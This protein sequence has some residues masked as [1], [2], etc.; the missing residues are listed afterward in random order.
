M[1]VLKRTGVYINNQQ[2]TINNKGREQ[3]ALKGKGKGKRKKFLGKEKGKVRAQNCPPAGLGGEGEGDG[4]L[5]RNPA[6]SSKTVDCGSL[7]R[8]PRTI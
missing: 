4:D 3:D 1:L 6:A 7:R 8:L 5:G 2:S